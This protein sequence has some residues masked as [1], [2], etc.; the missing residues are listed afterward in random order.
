[1]NLLKTYKTQ[2]HNINYFINS[3]QK[4]F[5][6]IELLLVIAIIGIFS[7]ILITVINPNSYLQPSRDSRRIKNILELQTAITAAVTTDKIKL[8]DTSSCS[9]CSSN[10]GTNAVDGTG[11]IKFENT[12]G[13]GL[14]DYM[15]SLPRDPINENNL[16]YY[17]YS[18]GQNFEI[19]ATLE[20][21][22][23]EL[24]AQDDGGNNNLIYERGWDLFLE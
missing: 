23:Y 18:D 21:E 17:F 10:T 11:W 24:N 4:A 6:L 2:R 5:T 16:Q 20:S 15:Q 3:Y 13:R 7:A 8:I 19:N 12:S 14:L 1:M 9:T 22:K